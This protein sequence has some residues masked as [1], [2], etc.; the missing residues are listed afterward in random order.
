MTDHYDR[1]SSKLA[2]AERRTKDFA[3][4]LTKK[5]VFK[6]GDTHDELKQC[7]MCLDFKTN[8]SFLNQRGRT[9]SGGWCFFCELKRLRIQRNLQKY[10]ASVL[11]SNDVVVHIDNFPDMI[12]SV[13][14]V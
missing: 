9:I 14:L 6:D 7:F 10:Y 13:K 3:S 11:R 2:E 12:F 8:S 5:L 1:L 4:G